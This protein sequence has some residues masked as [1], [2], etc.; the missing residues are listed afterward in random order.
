M[1]E[2]SFKLLNEI[3]AAF[4][5]SA[6]MMPVKIIP[7]NAI[8]TDNIFERGVDGRISPY[9]TVVAVIKAQYK[10]SKR[11]HDSRFPTTWLSRTMNKAKDINKG[12]ARPSP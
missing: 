12:A 6:T 8:I 9:P 10:A 4:I 2:T 3:L 11:D 7:I 5:A 1:A